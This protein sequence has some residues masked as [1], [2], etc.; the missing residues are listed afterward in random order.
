ME[1]T[2]DCNLLMRGSGLIG[3]LRGLET[4]S[5]E[6]IGPHLNTTWRSASCASGFILRT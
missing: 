1:A 6:T 5:S 3:L 4:P 2:G